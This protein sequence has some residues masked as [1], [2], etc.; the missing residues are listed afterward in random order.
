ML[1][2]T[3][4]IF[5]QPHPFFATHVITPKPYASDAAPPDTVH[6]IA[7]L[8][9]QTA[10]SIQSSRS[11]R[12]NASLPSLG[13][14]YAFGITS[15]GAAPTSTPMVHTPAH[16]VGTLSTMQP[17]AHVTELQTVLN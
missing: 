4:L 15:R 7:P 16:C 17:S 14:N 5:Q 8:P 9:L 10:Q 6:Q 11:G 2:T 13:K 3:T 12:T 1:E